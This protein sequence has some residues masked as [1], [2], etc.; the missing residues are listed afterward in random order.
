MTA[1]TSG[2]VFWLPGRETIAPIIHGNVNA[3]ALRHQSYPQ[4]YH[5]VEA[6]LQQPQPVEEIAWPILHFRRHSTYRK[7]A[8]LSVGPADADRR[9]A[10]RSAAVVLLVGADGR[11]RNAVRALD[12]EHLPAGKLAER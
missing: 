1:S 2:A 5:Q 9:R 8:W 6:G 3:L 10:L 12:N 7:V 11:A 4:P